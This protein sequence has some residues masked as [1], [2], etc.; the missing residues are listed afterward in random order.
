[1]ARTKVVTELGQ[2]AHED[3]L[4]AVH[5]LIDAGKTTAREIA[6]LAGDRG[7]RIEALKAELA[8][9]EGGKAVAGAPAA[10]RA[11]RAYHRKAKPAPRAATKAVASKPPKQRLG[12]KIVRSDGRSFTVTAAVVES[13]RL[14]GQYIGNLRKIPE[15]ERDRYRAVVKSKGVAAGVA[16]IKKRLGIA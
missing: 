14:Q 9:L 3:M 16:A 8:A 13:R 6:Q 11:K 5:C 10:P 1:M 12:R 2:V 15:R 7:A 4:Y